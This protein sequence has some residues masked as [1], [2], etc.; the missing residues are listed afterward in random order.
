MLS[1]RECMT[2][3]LGYCSGLQSTSHHLP[4]AVDL[5][6]S[7]HKLKT[8]P[9]NIKTQT[10]N[11]TWKYQNA[12]LKLHLEISKHKLVLNHKTEWKNSIHIEFFSFNSM[13][14]DSC[15]YLR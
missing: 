1:V 7:K 5:E 15:W 4:L 9:G 12:N 13:G 2:H 14:A 11:Y 6:I 8:G 3:F 10:E